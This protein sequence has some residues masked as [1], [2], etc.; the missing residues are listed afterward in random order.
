VN[1]GVPPQSL[2]SAEDKENKGVPM[3]VNIPTAEYPATDDTVTLAK[4]LSTGDIEPG[5][6][7]TEPKETVMSEAA[8]KA[9]RTLQSLVTRIKTREIDSVALKKLS[10]LAREYPVKAPLSVNNG[11]DNADIWEGGRIF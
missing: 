4:A 9:K 3:S 2:S 7:R 6:V 8:A 1:N 5:A 10:T 11:E